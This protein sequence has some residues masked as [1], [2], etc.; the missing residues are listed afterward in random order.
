MNAVQNRPA[1][2]VA[3]PLPTLTARPNHPSRRSHRRLQYPSL[4]RPTSA[5]LPQTQV[6]AQSNAIPSGSPSS[7]VQ[8]TIQAPES[9]RRL[10]SACNLINAPLQIVWDLLSDYSN[11]STHIP[12]L[13]ISEQTNHPSGGIRVIQSGAQRI[14]G[15]QFRASLTMD[16]TEVNPTS[17][18]WRAIN[19]DLVTS[20]DFRQFEGVW[21]MERVDSTRTALYYT[22]SIVPKGLVPV[23]AIEWRIAEDV[24]QNMDAVRREC[25]R[26]RR[27]AVAAGRRQQLARANKTQSQ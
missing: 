26:R 16:M 15:F 10:I 5:T 20:R 21:R 11:L 17:S 18:K 19:F 12:N 1:A 4:R 13:V 2:F 6:R 24:P 7:K 23:K 8:V 25:E 14:L 3:Q 9:N 27:V 22:V